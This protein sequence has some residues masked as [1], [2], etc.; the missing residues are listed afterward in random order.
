[1]GEEAKIDGKTKIDGRTKTAMITTLL[2][3]VDGTL[4]D[5]AAAEKNAIRGL[6]QEYGFGNC[7]DEMLARYSQINKTYW[8]CLERKEFTKPEILIKRFEDFFGMEGL[9]V[10]VAAEFNEKYQTSLGDTIVFHDD[11]YNIVKSLCGKV[12][13]YVVSNGTITAQSKKLKLSGLGELMDGIFLSEQLGVEKPD[14]RFFDKVFA[15]IQPADKAQVM[16]VGDSLSSDIQ[17]GNH[18]GIITCWY[19]PENKLHQGDLKIDHEIADLHEIY[20]LI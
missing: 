20:D 7:S 18:A 9:D 2:W 12:K 19:N 1:M 16:I 14:V 17:G 6:F 15:E 4:L 3:D 13:Q 8:E 5:F 11:G 10:T